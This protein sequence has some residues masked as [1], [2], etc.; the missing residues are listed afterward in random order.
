MKN[1]LK[2]RIFRSFI[3]LFSGDA[4][5]S[6]LSIISLTF[7]TKGIGMEK[8]GFIV[9]LQGIA[10]LFDG[11]FNFQSWQGFIKFFPER[12]DNPEE[13]KSLIKFSYLQDIITAI[14]AF[15]VLNICKNL[16]GNFYE[17]TNVQIVML[18]IFSMYMVFNIQGTPIGILRSYDRFDALRNQRAIGGIV[19]FILL[20]AGYILKQD[21]LYFL[22]AYAIS[23][24]FSSGLLNFYALRELKKRGILD[25]YKVHSKFDKEFFKFNCF[26]NLNSSLDIPIQ[27]LDNLLVGKYLSLEEL[28][29]YKI[30]KTVALVLDKVATP[31]YQI[32]YPYFCNEIKDG[33][34][35]QMYKKLYKISGL[36]GL[37]VILILIGLN[38]VG[39]YIL[40]KFF[41]SVILNYKTAINF[42][43]IAKG[44][45]IT[46]IGIHPLFLA[47]G[48]VKKETVI[49]LVANGIYLV[50]LFPLLKAF[51]LMG[52][53]G[54]YLI[55]VMLII[56]LKTST[57]Y[58]TIKDN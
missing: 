56:L 10:G 21:T 1:I 8:Y 31:V 28:G 38:T 55:Q 3:S 35:K 23:T 48:Y 50:A 25:F 22:G 44:I 13:L 34:S 36:L 5:A 51:G 24:V 4:I 37:G 54:A 53:I 2:D 7:I 39:F 47:K 33:R 46:F 6:V 9:L 42:Y 52:V 30:C 57:V 18:Q 20:G 17:F 49:I 32:L 15:G 40:G 58:Y 45:A 27:Y 41:G 19:N 14:I 16:V 29:I 26:T 11:I 43:L 12:K